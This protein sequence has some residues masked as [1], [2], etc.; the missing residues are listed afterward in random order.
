MP[1]SAHSFGKFPCIETWDDVG[2]VPYADL[3][4]QQLRRI[5]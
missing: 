5:L 2:I 3:G 1:T 4:K